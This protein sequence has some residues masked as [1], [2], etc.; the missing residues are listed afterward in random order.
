MDLLDNSAGEGEVRWEVRA[1]IGELL[2]ATVRK[3]DIGELIERLGNLDAA[4]DKLLEIMSAITDLLVGLESARSIADAIAIIWLKKEYP[5]WARNPKLRKA[6]REL[7][8][9]RHSNKFV[10][11]EFGDFERVKVHFQVEDKQKNVPPRLARYKEQIIAQAARND[12]EE[13]L[14]LP[15]LQ[16]EAR[17]ETAK[18]D[19]TADDLWA[20]GP[21][22]SSVHQ[23]K[24]AEGEVGTAS[25]PSASSLGAVEAMEKAV[26]RLQRFAG[27]DERR[28]QIQDRMVNILIRVSERRRMEVLGILLEP[29]SYWEGDEEYA[30]VGRTVIAFVLQEVVP[31]LSAGEIQQV[32]PQTIIA[33]EEAEE[34]SDEGNALKTQIGSML[35]I[36][37]MRAMRE[38][39]GIPSIR[40]IMSLILPIE[41]AV[42]TAFI[43][44]YPF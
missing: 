26:R 14:G 9:A 27:D 41:K 33:L 43:R 28:E 6:L 35:E 18:D 44:N 22:A 38:G 8:L 10:F 30:D 42:Q 12:T 7:F 17:S 20:S 2:V 15:R 1:K 37:T 25:R 23:Q 5:E 13:K 31:D 34:N 24:I 11:P 32:I 40:E 21:Q 29:M 39:S 16:A 19:G 3:S 36:L 4:I